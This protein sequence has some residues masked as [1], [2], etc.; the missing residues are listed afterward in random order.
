ML[1]YKAELLSDINKA[2][3]AKSA[4][5]VDPIVYW[6]DG[7]SNGSKPQLDHRCTIEHM[8]I[9]FWKERARIMRQFSLNLEEP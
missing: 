5:F 6:P 4:W 1:A 7:P 3:L 2:Y 9:S 8:I